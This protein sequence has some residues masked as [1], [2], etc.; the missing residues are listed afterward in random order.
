M[1]IYLVLKLFDK[2]YVQGHYPMKID[3]LYLIGKFFENISQDSVRSGKTCPAKLGVRSCPVGKL[4]CPVRSG[5]IWEVLKQC[6]I[7]QNTS[8]FRHISALGSLLLTYNIWDGPIHLTLFQEW[9]AACRCCC[10]PYPPWSN[11][12]QK[13]SINR[14][15][16]YWLLDNY[17]Y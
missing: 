8:I 12:T 5:P 3:N 7:L 6:A 10:S 2:I 16:D 13:L 17:I 15:L 1:F 14:K 4:I 9:A 11:I